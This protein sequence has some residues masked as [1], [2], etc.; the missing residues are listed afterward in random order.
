[1]EFVNDD[2]SVMQF[3]QNISSTI[4]VTSESIQI[5]APNF[6]ITV[7]QVSPDL[8]TP[9]EEIIIPLSSDELENYGTA[10][11]KRQRKSIPDPKSWKKMKANAED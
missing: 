10:R 5:P 11:K 2:G 6:P 7:S 3:E 9:K 4:L 8:D 1:M